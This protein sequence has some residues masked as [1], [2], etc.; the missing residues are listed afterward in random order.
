MRTSTSKSCRISLR[1]AATSTLGTVIACVLCLLPAPAAIAAEGDQA[2]QEA[3]EQLAEITVTARKREESFKDVPVALTVLTGPVLERYDLSSLEKIAAATP[4]FTVARASNG[5]AASLSIRGVGSSFT[6]IG[7]EQS[8]AVV[9]DGI[10]YGQGR[11]IN[12]GLYDIQRVELLKGPQALFFGKNGSAGVVSVVSADPTQEFEALARVGYETK[13]HQPVYEAMISGGLSDAW[14]ARLAVRASTM[15]RGYVKNVAT[16]QDFGFIDVATGNTGSTQAAPADRYGP[17]ED[18]YAG[19]ITLKYAPGDAFSNTTKLSGSKSKTGNGSWNYIVYDCPAAGAPTPCGRD[20]VNAMNDLPAAAGATFPWAKSDGTLHNDYDSF[21]ITDTAQFDFGAWNL[22]S[23]LNYQRFKNIFSIDA[24]YYS[25]ATSS[26]WADQSDK[27][28]AYSGELRA[29][30]D[31]DGPFNFLVGALYQKTKLDS[32]QAVILAGIQNSAAPLEENLF[33]TFNK[34]SGTDGETFSAFAQATWKL[35]EQW[36]IDA[37]ARFTHETKKSDFQHP[38]VNPALASLFVQGVVINADQSW[39]NVSP[40]ATVSWKPS[41]EV[42]LYGAFKTGYKSGG[43]SNTAILTVNTTAENFQFGPEKPRGFE[44]GLKSQLLSRTLNF[45]ATVYDYKFRDLQLEV[46]NSSLVSFTAG[47]AGSARTR[48]IETEI[49]WLPPG[50]DGLTLNA[51]LN[52]NKS[53][54]EN[55]GRAPCYA[56]Q[57]IAQGCSLDPLQAGVSF[58]DLTGAPTA[59]APK[60]TGN[61]G[62]SWDRALPMGKLILAANGRY[63]DSYNISQYNNPRTIQSSYIMW[64]ASAKLEFGDGWEIGVIG[65]NLSNKFV[66]T[67]TLDVVGGGSGTGTANGIPA[68]QA[69]LVTLPRTVLL[70]VGKRF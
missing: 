8:V 9:V 62:F 10:Y 61:L 28:R 34:A 32:A 49:E 53:E 48:G 40:E 69:G 19:R 56:G 14:S 4:Q 44:L 21:Q 23:A 13:A 64:D 46:F 67:G 1:L 55:F 60:W 35:N 54:Y 41:D 17:D 6:S 7:I 20:F 31:L 5:S 39:N 42:T 26:T 12:E 47:N 57:T 63:S 15:S 30:T 59:V 68:N 24:D 52:Y 11:I 58:Q 22:T 33:E 29:Q 25:A 38:Y 3:P 18:G 16:A 27:Y 45:V 36:T 66:L 70:Q 43:F 2:A 37:G 51:S 65:R 50:M